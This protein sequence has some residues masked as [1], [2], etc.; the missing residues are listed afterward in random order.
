[1]S[2]YGQLIDQLSRRVE[3]LREEYE[4]AKI[5]T[6]HVLA[7]AEA[8]GVDRIGIN[9]IDKT[10]HE[11][12]NFPFA[13]RGSLFAKGRH[14]NGWPVVWKVAS[15]AGISGGAGNTDQHQ[16]QSVALVDG[17][18]ELRDGEWRMVEPVGGDA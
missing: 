12:G 17:I 5:M 11:T 4:R 6:A 8:N 10:V 9:T 2:D 7:A 1:M 14:E 15:D 3:S 16:I 13:A 18:Y